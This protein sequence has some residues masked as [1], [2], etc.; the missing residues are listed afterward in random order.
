MFTLEVP[1]ELLCIPFQPRRKQTQKRAVFPRQLQHPLTVVMPVEK[2]L[3]GVD[4]IQP[5]INLVV[6]HLQK[7]IVKRLQKRLCVKPL[8]LLIRHL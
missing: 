4:L 1:D 7:P 6:G 8:G 3:L 5:L 2:R